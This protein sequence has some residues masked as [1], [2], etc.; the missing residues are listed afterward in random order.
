MYIN[1]ITIS[2]NKLRILLVNLYF[3]IL[4]YKFK[5]NYIC[6]NNYIYLL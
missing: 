2:Y 6:K 5:N 1:I 3:Y 4:Q